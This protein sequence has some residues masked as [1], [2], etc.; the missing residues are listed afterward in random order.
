MKQK[1]LFYRI[2]LFALIFISIYSCIFIGFHFYIPILTN[3]TATSI[4]DPKYGTQYVTL[5][6]DKPDNLFYVLIY[7]ETDDENWIYYA[8]KSYNDST[9]LILSQ[10]LPENKTQ[11]MLL[12]GSKSTTNLSFSLKPKYN[13]STLANKEHIFHVIYIVP[14]NFYIF[15]TFYYTKHS[16][17][18]VDPIL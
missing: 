10:F 5:N 4:P 6:I 12:E 7:E 8:Q 1:S 16:I 15:P 17:F 9:E 3:V 2:T 18:F 14:K 11:Y 13:L